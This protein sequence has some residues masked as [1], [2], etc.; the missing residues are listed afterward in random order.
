MKVLGISGSPRKDGNTQILIQT[1]LD[2]LQEE[3][4]ETELLSLAGRPVKPCVA[5]GGCAKAEG[6]RCVQEDPAFEGIIDR[7]IEADGVL[8]GSPVYFG[9]A[10]P[11]IMA[12]LDRVGYVSRSNG[13]FLRRKAG[14]AV[15]VARRAGQNFTFAQLNYFFLISEM[16][17]PGSTYWN[18]AFGR[19]KGQVASDQEGLD[20]VKTLAK[21]MAWL[22]RKLGG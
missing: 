3:G 20:T 9:S 18:I 5:C 4:I 13:N 2:V 16:I 15:V 10:T 22:L 12:L 1:A 14:A 19:E 17:V 6:I 7:F 8:V 21:N 11:E